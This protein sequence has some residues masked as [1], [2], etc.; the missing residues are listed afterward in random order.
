VARMV[1]SYCRSI[2]L[3]TQV[4]VFILGTGATGGLLARL[5]QR[6]GQQVMCEDAGPTRAA[7]FAGNGIDVVR[8]NA[9]RSNGLA[10]AGARP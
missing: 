5:L 3:D 10:G 7:L 2:P 4:K 1:S 6:G 8:V 9:R